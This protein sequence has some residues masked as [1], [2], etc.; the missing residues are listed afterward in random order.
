MRIDVFVATR[1]DNVGEILLVRGL[2]DGIRRH[3]QGELCSSPR[4]ANM[5]YEDV[6][7]LCEKNIH[8]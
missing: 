8:L 4:E 6:Y 5:F 1:R 3:A 2:R 7:T